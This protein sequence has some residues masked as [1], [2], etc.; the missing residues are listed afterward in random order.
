MCPTISKNEIKA[1]YIIVD[2]FSAYIVYDD[3]TIH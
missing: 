2:L 1:Y 3:N